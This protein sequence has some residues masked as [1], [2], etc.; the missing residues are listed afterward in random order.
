ML[1]DETADSMDI[2]LAQQAEGHGHAQR[3]ELGRVHEDTEE[4]KRMGQSIAETTTSTPGRRPR[5]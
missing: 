4:Y 5:P 1:E 2:Q 3:L